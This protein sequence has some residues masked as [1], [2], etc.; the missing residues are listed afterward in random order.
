VVRWFLRLFPYV[1]ALEELNARHERLE[2]YLGVRLRPFGAGTEAD[3]KRSVELCLA[4]RAPLG[5]TWDVTVRTL[6]PGV[7]GIDIDIERK[8]GKLV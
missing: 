8:A 4:E 5:M 7:V 6:G 2:R 3:V 1:R